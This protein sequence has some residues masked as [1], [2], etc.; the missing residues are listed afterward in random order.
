VLVATELHA[1]EGDGDHLHGQAP[2]LNRIRAND[3]NPLNGSDRPLK[4]ETLVRSPLGLPPKPGSDAVC[5]EES[6]GREPPASSFAT[7][8]NFTWCAR[9]GAKPKPRSWP[10][11]AD[12]SDSTLF[13]SLTHIHNRPRQLSDIV[14]VMAYVSHFR[15]IPSLPG[16]RRSTSGFTLGGQ[17]EDLSFSGLFLGTY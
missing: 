14:N 10:P 5:C 15:T 13:V 1:P 12:V 7:G 8:F 3:K 9:P 2:H 6:L 4:V 16:H 11:C 17:V